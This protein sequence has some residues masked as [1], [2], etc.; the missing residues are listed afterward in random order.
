MHG[1]VNIAGEVVY[2][3]N[4]LVENIGPIRLVD[5][6]AGI[7]ETAELVATN[8]FAPTVSV[9]FDGDGKADLIFHSVDGTVWVNL[10]TGTG[11]TAPQLWLRF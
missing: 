1:C 9:D 6:S 2:E 11:F 4:Y 5:S 8:V 3:I 7:T 10:S